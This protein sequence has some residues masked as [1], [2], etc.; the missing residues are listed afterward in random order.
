[1]KEEKSSEHTQ[2]FVIKRDVTIKNNLCLYQSAMYFFK[3]A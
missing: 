2:E 3:I 1:M